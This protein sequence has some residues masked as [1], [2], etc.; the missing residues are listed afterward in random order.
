MAKIENQAIPIENTHFFTDFYQ[1]LNDVGFGSKQS[2]RRDLLP[3]W[4]CDEFEQRPGAIIEASAYV[5]RRTGI[6]FEALMES[7]RS[8]A[9]AEG[10]KL[11][12]KLRQGTEESS[13]AIARALGEQVAKLVAYA[14]PTELQ[15]VEGVSAGTIRT[16]ILSSGCADSCGVTLKNLLRFCWQRGV[17]VVHLSNLPSGNGKKKFD[18]MV[19]KFNARPVIAIGSGRQSPAWL[20]FILAHELGHIV[21]GHVAEGTSIVDENINPEDGEDEQELVADRFAVELIYGRAEAAY[22]FLGQPTSNKIAEFAVQAG[23]RDHIHPASVA[24]NYAWL[25]GREGKNVWGL[26][27]KLLKQFEK[28]TPTAQEII[29]RHL[30]SQLDWETLSDDNCEFL[31]RIASLA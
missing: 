8:L 4:W 7:G 5:S 25:M 18:G 1:R 19:G 26:V 27:N 2:V 20:A 10:S 17:P 15:S 29:G 3:D 24:L 16:E 6:T 23:A 9:L 30:K 14:C 13:L 11:C 28:N 12:Y 31:E 21:A 22:R